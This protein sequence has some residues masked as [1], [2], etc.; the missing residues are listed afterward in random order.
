MNFLEP[1]LI[2]D[3]YPTYARWQ[4]EQ[5]IFRAEDTGQ[6]VLTRHDD[7]RSVLKS[8]V[9]YSSKAMGEQ[10]NP[11]PLLTDDPPKHTQLRALV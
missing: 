11:L 6:W 3:P 8:S 7:V 10:G 1:D 4:A 9:D 5:P 2:A